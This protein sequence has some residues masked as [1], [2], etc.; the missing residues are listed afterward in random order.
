MFADANQVMIELKKDAETDIDESDYVLKSYENQD[1]TVLVSDLSGF[2]STTR[3]W[4]ITHF[5]S[6]IIRMR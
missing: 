1:V 4:G 2:T 6:V 5:A 3:K